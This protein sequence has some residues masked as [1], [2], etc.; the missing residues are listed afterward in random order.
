MRPE[1]RLWQSTARLSVVVVTYRSEADI[2]G[3]LASVRAAAREIPSEVVVVDNASDDGTVST[4]RREHAEVTLRVND[5]NLG[6]ASGCNAGIGMTT[7]TY[8]LLL[9]PDVR[10]QPGTMPALMAYLDAHPEVGIV[11]P[12]L[13]AASGGLQRDISA[14]GLF[15]SFVQALFEYA[16]LGQWFPTNR[17]VRDYFLAGFDRRSVR[18]VAMVQGACLLVRREV[19]RQVGPLDERFFLYFEE[20]DL[21]KRAADSGWETHYVGSV[22]ATHTG[23]GSSGDRRPLAREFI[24]SLYAFHR[25]HHG[26][27]EAA[28]LW[29]ILAPYH[30]AKTARLYVESRLHPGNQRLRSD[31]QVIA[32]RCAAHLQLLIPRRGELH[33][34]DRPRIR[35]IINERHEAGA[36]AQLEPGPPPLRSIH[37]AREPMDEPTRVREPGRQPA[38]EPGPSITEIAPPG[39]WIGFEVGELWQYRELLLTFIVRELRLRYAQTWIGAAWVL[40][41]P[42]STMALLWAVFGVVA[43]LPT[44]GVPYAL[45]CF[46]GLV[47]WF[48]FAGAVAD[49]QESLVGNAEL[50]RKVYF[51]RPLLP[52]ATVSAR[53]VDLTIMLA[54]LATLLV[55]HRVGRLP[56]VVA[57]GAVILLTVMLATGVG[58]AVA[59][60]NVRFRDAQH[61]V[62]VALQLLMF[63]SPVIYS[64]Q[65]V[66]PAW[67]RLYM[68]NPLAGLVEGF[69]AAVLG[70][71][72]PTEALTVS[73]VVTTALLTVTFLMFRRMETAFADQV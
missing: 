12:A 67:R 44:N 66:P 3:C 42:V 21:C 55:Y 62:P 56:H 73:A 9:N 58:M 64:S 35:T 45:F 32:E 59:A 53:L 19:L 22:A 16:P 26:V 72:L 47:L 70:L 60:I 10:L 18:R 20:T 33:G 50:I 61:V 34:P 24:R 69:R 6:F 68:L 27:L 15:P 41:K 51:P 71:P 37:A 11:G 48:F 1:A 63:A 57:M 2:A 28:A 65:M 25:K 43:A 29:T 13:E 31:L 39:R 30:L 38:G 17:W 54:F 49:S 5:R 4:V 7:G 52:I 8:V 14:T 36:F 23:A 40:L 46:S